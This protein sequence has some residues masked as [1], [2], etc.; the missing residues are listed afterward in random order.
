MQNKRETEKQMVK[1]GQKM[2]NT[3]RS[4]Q[5]QKIYKKITANKKQK[6]NKKKNKKK[7][8]KKKTYTPTNVQ[9]Q[10]AKGET[11]CQAPGGLLQT[12]TFRLLSKYRV[13][14]QMNEVRRLCPKH[15]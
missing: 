3:T 13:R 2:G 14:P 11:F 10:R 5:T 9:S 6:K 4:Q 7:Q 1:H 12:A 8:K 15:S